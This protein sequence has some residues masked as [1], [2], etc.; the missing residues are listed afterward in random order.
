ML[1]SMKGTYLGIDSFV[2]EQIAQVITFLAL[3]TLHKRATLGGGPTRLL[4][5]D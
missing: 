5:V 4:G 1:T 3:D 2:H